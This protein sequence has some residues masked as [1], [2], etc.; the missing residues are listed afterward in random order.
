[1]AKAVLSNLDFGNATK[2]VNVPDPTSAQ[3]VATK[4]YVDSAI[5][6]LAWKDSVRAA[7]T[8][9]VTVSSAP[10]TLDGITLAAS[11][12]VLL[13]NQTTASENGIYIFAAASSALTRSPDA[14]TAASLEQ[15]VV[16]VEEGTSNS[17]TNWRQTTVNFTLGSGSI[18]WESFGTAVPDAT[19][20]T[21]GKVQLAQASD[22]VTG[23][24]TT[25]VVTPSALAGAS[26][27]LKKVSATIG[28][29]SATQFDVDITAIGS[30]AVVWEVYDATTLQAVLCDVKH[31][32]TTV[33][34]LN[35]AVAP[36]SSGI[37]VVVVG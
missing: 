23:T 20:S 30:A 9:N 17:D 3:D 6:G 37:K 16:G 24:S 13:K 21:K 34:R 31:Q 7:S 5:L 19:T 32:S 10:S 28:D 36:A 26:T 33:L 22:V 14:N 12:R 18:A 1:M 2:P 15:A 27:I 25:L 4:N 11:D 29:G 35:F 8:A